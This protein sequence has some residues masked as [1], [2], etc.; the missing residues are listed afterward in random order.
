MYYRETYRVQRE[1]SA[2]T[3]DETPGFL[4]PPL[5][6]TDTPSIDFPVIIPLEVEYQEMRPESV[7]TSVGSEEVDSDNQ[8][9]IRFLTARNGGKTKKNIFSKMP[10]Y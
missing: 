2:P 1:I 4:R 7:C 9:V 3:W 6:I 5:D 8:T 10:H